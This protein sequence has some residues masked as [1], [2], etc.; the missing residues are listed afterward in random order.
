MVKHLLEDCQ[1]GAVEGITV[2]EMRRALGLLEVNC[3]EVHSFV[4]QPIAWDRNI[5][6]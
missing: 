4:R 1:A 2:A 6:L 5:N 3:Y